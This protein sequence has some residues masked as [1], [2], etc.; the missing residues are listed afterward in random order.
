MPLMPGWCPVW[1]RRCR[2]GVLRV[3][4][5]ARLVGLH[6]MKSYSTL[7]A[8]QVPQLW[9]QR[10]PRMGQPPKGGSWCI[11]DYWLPVHPM[12]V[13]WGFIP[14]G[15]VLHSHSVETPVPWTGSQA[16]VNTRNGWRSSS[17]P[18]RYAAWEPDHRRLIR[19]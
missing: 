16:V 19:H 5:R 1:V 9:V 4:R 13:F 14:T 7:D 8:E 17:L 18:V 6:H 12:V 15:R 2:G 3:D 11:H 10:L